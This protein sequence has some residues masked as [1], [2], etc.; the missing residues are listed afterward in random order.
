MLPPPSESPRL[1]QDS[2][3]S[4]SNPLL[5]K[6]IINISP[7]PR[8]RKEKRSRNSHD[9][10]NGI[11]IIHADACERPT[12]DCVICYN[13]IDVGN[14]SDYMLAPCNHIFHRQC[15]T[16]WMDVKMECPVCRTKL[17]SL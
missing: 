9:E 13:D 1:R 16:Q 8:N 12:L 4:E 10:S 5:E 7:G 11:T 6:D 17:P 14:R 15:L 2:D 3:E